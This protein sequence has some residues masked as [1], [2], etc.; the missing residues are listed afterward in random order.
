MWSKTRISSLH[1]IDLKSIDNNQNIKI[2]KV[3]PLDS[4][5]DCLSV[6]VN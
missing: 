1:N 5:L 3:F 2:S 6:D 4:L